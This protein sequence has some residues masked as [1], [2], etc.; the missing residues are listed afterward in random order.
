MRSEKG[1]VIFWLPWLVSFIA[2]SAYPI[3]FSLGASLFDYDL[4][5]GSAK[6]AGLRNYREIFSDSLFWLA[7]RNTL[8]FVVGTVFPTAVLS[9]LLALGIRRTG[10]LMGCLRAGY[11]VPAVISLAVV[12]L[13]FK[14]IYS[15]HGFLNLLMEGWGL[16]PRGWLVDPNL[17]LPSIMVINVWSSVGYYAIF[18]L[19]GLETIPDEVF[20]AARMD[21]AGGLSLLRFI[22]VPLLKPVLLFVLVINTIRA[23]QVFVE[24]VVMTRGGPMG[25]TM[26]LVYYMYEKAFH[27]T[28]IGTASAVAMVLFLMIAFFSLIQARMIRHA[29]EAF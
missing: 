12:S 6:W 15:P 9:L 27:L 4:L 13:I 11:F 26:T 10:R 25:S 3:L 16:K 14:Y 2:F 24:I 1:L 18:F 22:T 29:G 5:A 23:F 21:G 19:A 7:L 17:A 20:E 28:K 8:F